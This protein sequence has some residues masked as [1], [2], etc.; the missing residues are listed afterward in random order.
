[1]TTTVSLNENWRFKKENGDW[2]SVTIP[3]S[4]NGNDGQDG[5][6][7][8]RGKGIYERTIVLNDSDLQ[9]T[10][11][12]EVNAAAVESTVYINGSVAYTNKCPY[13]MYRIPLNEYV[14][15]GD[16]RIRVEADNSYNELI[17]P[18]M[19]DFSF[20]GGLY[21]DVNLI[22]GDRI[23][24]DYLDG[25]RDGVYISAKNTHEQIW[26]MSVKGTV[27]NADKACDVSVY[28]ILRDKDEIV[29]E[30]SVDLTVEERADF[31]MTVLI[32]NPHLWQ[33]IKDPYL[34]CVQVLI[35]VEGK[36]IDAREIPFGFRKIEL[37]AEKGLF[38][39]GEHVKLRGMARHQDFV[40][41]GNAV[42]KEQMERDMELLLELGANSVRLSHYQHDDY[43]Y[44]LCDKNGILTW[45]E[46]PFISAAPENEEAFE[47]IKEQMERLIKQC[48]NH[49]S[50]YCWGIQNEITVA[51]ENEK[52]YQYVEELEKFAKNLDATRYTSE[53]NIYSVSN[54]SLLNSL[55]DLVGYN[56]YYGWY[57]K[58]IPDLQ[59][60]LDEFHA[61]VPNIPL[62]VTEYG[63]DTNPVYHSY[64]PAVKDY[65]EEY[66]L[67]FC[68]NA[69]R[70]F[71]ERDFVMG[72]YVWNLADFGSE[73][74]DEGG[75]KGQ[76]MKG[77]VTIDRKLKKDAFYLYK[78][79]WSEERFVKFASSRFVNRHKEE[80][81][82]TVLS[83][84]TKLCLYVDGSLTGETEDVKAVTQF[85]VQLPELRGYKITVKGYDK[86]GRLYEDEM[87]LV[88]VA[89][90]D[91]SYVVVKQDNRLNVAN[92]FEKFDLSDATEIEIDDNY[93]STRDTL[94]C[95][96]E[97][98]EAKVIVEKYLE[99]LLKDPRLTR[100]KKMTVDALSKL[101]GL[102][103][104]KELVPVMN[105]ELN[106]IKK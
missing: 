35:I 59:R 47:N 27:T 68:D 86:Q 3:H 15:V 95:L 83:N 104:P 82:I 106:K 11:F 61:E 94:E 92:W 48:Y 5:T 57:Y 42:S 76:N 63:V 12:L 91:K 62:L 38:L 21:R 7:M 56:L 54:T 66:Q 77:L 43:F 85:T 29:S 41:V 80:N 33:G 8:W 19:A 102:G 75:R 99:I 18:Q 14:T 71:E 79:Y 65:T 46:V 51:C 1:M 31:D 88:R 98:E 93:Y 78:A 30:K 74:R 81:V 53:A 58:T 26:E 2:E 13:S 89:E 50:I 49:T 39:N 32:E 16:N 103:M 44:Q 105:R 55:T 28:C 70:A 87:N 17:Y 36:I 23:S 4:W 6:G 40:E 84:L 101:S 64:E 72:S 9:K 10:L 100:A 25:S 24:F 34:Y 96:L 67:C 69:I 90:A 22:I 52:V 20:Y 97:N 60:R 73:N 37:S 45:A